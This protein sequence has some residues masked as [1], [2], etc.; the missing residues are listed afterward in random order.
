MSI[1]FFSVRTLFKWKYFFSDPA[2]RGDKKFGDKCNQTDECGFAN[3]VCEA[4]KKTCQCEPGYPS[5][6]QID[7][8]GKRKFEIFFYWD[9]TFLNVSIYFCYCHFYES[10]MF[11]L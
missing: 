11:F 8:C 7:K 1:S 3:S 6:N 10:L 2:T 9:I 4:G 5:S